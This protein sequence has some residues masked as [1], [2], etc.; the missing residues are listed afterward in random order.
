MRDRSKR[1][2]PYRQRDEP[3]VADVR[4]DTFGV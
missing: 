1:N 3:R 2:D 4:A